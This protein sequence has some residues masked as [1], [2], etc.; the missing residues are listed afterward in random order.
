MTI[1]LYLWGEILKN[2]KRLILILIFQ[3]HSWNIGGNGTGPF[4]NSGVDHVGQIVHD[5]YSRICARTTVFCAGC[6]E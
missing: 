5:L 2:Y 6:A 4:G 1:I 3:P